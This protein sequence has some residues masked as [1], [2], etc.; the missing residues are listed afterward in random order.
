MRV[1]LTDRRAEE[2]AKTRAQGA[3][4]ARRKQGEKRKLIELATEN[5]REVLEHLQQQWLADEAR[6][7]GAVVDLQE[8][9]D[10]P[11]LPNRIEC[12]DI[13]H[14]QGTN[15]VGSMVVFENGQPRRS[16]YRRFKIKHEFGN[17]DFL[18]MQEV[19][20]RRFRARAARS[21]AAATASRAPGSETGDAEAEAR[22]TGR[23][24]GPRCPTW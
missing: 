4:S 22:R 6:T 3:R 7:T 21:A 10:L 1:W 12:Y 9:L 16:A 8:Y 13:S 18:S 19:I 17:N 5:A 20:G 24:S 11:Q 14:V 2:S 23:A 15:Q